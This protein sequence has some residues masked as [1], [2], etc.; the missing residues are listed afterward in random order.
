M[1]DPGQTLS[2][3]EAA[4]VRQARVE[5]LRARRAAGAPAA[6]PR[7]NAV[8]GPDAAGPRPGPDRNR[9][10]RRHVAQGARIAV[11]GASLTGLFGLVAAMAAAEVRS[12]QPQPA[13]VPVPAVA[14]PP[15]GV[16]A[17]T[18]ADDGRLVVQPPQALTATPQVVSVTPDPAQTVVRT[19]GSR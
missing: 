17:L 12:S 10:R 19:N 8:T 5:A 9:R 4:A 1:T 16:P 3:A 7:A 11:A 6:P 2:E 13:S 14:Q 15:A 18:V